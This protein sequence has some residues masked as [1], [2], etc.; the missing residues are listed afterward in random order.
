MRDKLV[1]LGG[2]ALVIAAFVYASVIG[3]AVLCYKVPGCPEI[4]SIILGR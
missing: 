2:A 3:D 4:R 1:L